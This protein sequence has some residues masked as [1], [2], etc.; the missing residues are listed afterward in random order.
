MEPGHL[1][2]YKVL[3][4]SGS[5]VFGPRLEETCTSVSCALID[6]DAVAGK[7]SALSEVTRPGS[8]S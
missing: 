3:H 6:E 5:L 4:D 7:G 1:L 8:S 2:F